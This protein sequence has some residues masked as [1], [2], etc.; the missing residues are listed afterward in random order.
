VRWIKI[1]MK[2]G[3]KKSKAEGGDLMLKLSE[4]KTW[5]NINMIY[6][7]H[8]ECW[9]IRVLSISSLSLCRDEL[10]LEL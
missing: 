1:K 7:F 6:I 3:E 9:M 5:D 2:R 4:E 10:G 8:S